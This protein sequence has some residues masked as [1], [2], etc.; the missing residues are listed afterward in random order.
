MINV[1]GIIGFMLSILGLIIAYIQILSVKQITQITQQK[2]EDGIQLNNDILMI[3]DLSRKAAIVDEIQGYL[4]DDKIDMCILRMKDLKLILNSL[5]YQSQYSQLFSKKQF[6]NAFQS[7]N[8]DLN[9]FQT[10]H[11]NNRIDKE[12]VLRNL[13]ELSTLLLS[14]EV[15]LKTPRT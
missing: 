3:S 7:F 4:K 8:I 9:N 14:V 13:E 15:K 12:I 2:V 10:A 5:R 11:L 1:I 6:S